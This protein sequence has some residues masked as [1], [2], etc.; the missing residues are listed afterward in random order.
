MVVALMLSPQE[1]NGI[2]HGEINCRNMLIELHGAIE[3]SR[4]VLAEPSE[5]N[6][7]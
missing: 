6:I 5:K 2:V 7:R 4:I 3:K 1:Q